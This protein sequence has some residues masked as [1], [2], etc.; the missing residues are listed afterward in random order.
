MTLKLTHIPTG[1]S[2]TATELGP[3]T[4]AQQKAAKDRLWKELWPRLEADVAAVLR[5]PRR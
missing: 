3:F 4:R 1:V 2:V 5:I